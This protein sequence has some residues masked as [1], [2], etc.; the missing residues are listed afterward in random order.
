MD[1]SVIVVNWNTR[2]LLAQCLNSIYANPPNCEFDIWVVDNASSDGSAQM[3]REQFSNVRLIENGE[4]LGFARANNQAI[5]ES[6]GTHLL[7]LNSD[8]VV[9]SDA[10]TR[11]LDF[12]CTHPQAGII[13]AF[14]LNRDGSPQPSALRFP[15]FWS[16]TFFAFGLDSRLPFALWLGRRGH[17]MGEW[18]RSDCV[19]GA[20]FMIKRLVLDMV[21]MFDEKFYMYSDEVDLQLRSKQAGWEIYVLPSAPVVHLG[22]AST[23][24]S[25]EKMKAELFSSK[26]YY[27]R[28]H[29]SRVSALAL[30]WVF[31]ASILGRILKYYLVGNARER[32]MWIQAWKHFRRNESMEGACKRQTGDNLTIPMQP[33]L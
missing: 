28:K 1:L 6:I 12:Q 20:A 21:G 10:L 22:A 26:L 3:V 16:E 23:R 11:L 33:I 32:D 15:S 8:T 27:F 30:S 4:N 2:E 7:F 14:L 24:Q 19:S 29:H 31:K 18:V 17:F 5:R 9:Q 13:G 25:A